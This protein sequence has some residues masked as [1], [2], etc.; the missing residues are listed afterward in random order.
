MIDILAPRQELCNELSG[1][2][3]EQLL[4]IPKRKREENERRI[5]HIAFE[6]TTRLLEDCNE[7]EAK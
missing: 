3:S 7:R 1:L 6:L 4:N 5:G 2:T